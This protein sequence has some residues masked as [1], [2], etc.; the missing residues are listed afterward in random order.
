MAVTP[1]DIESYFEQYGWSFER[2]S[3]N[4]FRTGFRGDVS[5]FRITVRLVENWVY[6]SISPFVVAPQDPDCERKLYKHLLHLNH[7][8][9]MAKFTIDQ[10]GDVILTV[11]LP[12]EQLDYSEFSDAL[13]ALSYYADDNYAQVFILAHMPQIHESLEEKD[14]DWNAE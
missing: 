4:D 7:E 3:E 8:I 11:E 1:T 13:G 6:F 2:I 14:L 10:D 9:N 5:V 12:S